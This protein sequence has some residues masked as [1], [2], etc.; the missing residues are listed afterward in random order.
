[1]RNHRT[2]EYL[3]LPE[4]TGLLPSE[5][6][7]R[8]VP[9]KIIVQ[10]QNFTS[11]TECYFK[12]ISAPTLYLTSSYL[13]C[14]APVVFAGEEVQV[15]LKERKLYF[16]RETKINLKYYASP[17]VYRVEPR[18][19]FRTSPGTEVRVHVSNLHRITTQALEFQFCKFGIYTVQVSQ[20]LFNLD[21]KSRTNFTTFVCK[22]PYFP[23]AEKVL[24][25]ILTDNGVFSSS[26]N[27]E[28]E[29][30]D[31]PIVRLVTPHYAPLGVDNVEFKLTG[32]V[33][34]PAYEYFC[35][36]KLAHTYQNETKAFFITN[37]ELKCVVP[38]GSL[39]RH[40][41]YVTIRIVMKDLSRTFSYNFPAT[42]RVLFYS[43]LSIIKFEP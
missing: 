39:V 33:F 38:S 18:K 13:E 35:Q 21:P 22:T 8:D 15:M 42:T 26:L 7:T 9:Q 30:I 31:P 37:K 41:Q 1:M 4:L 20:I 12:G 2:L 34:D 32:G 23:S 11:E 3:K 6:P 43:P 14:D 10:G 40:T 25:E 29:F 5:V 36:Y 17:F 28:F 16:N 24:V 19:A 27:N